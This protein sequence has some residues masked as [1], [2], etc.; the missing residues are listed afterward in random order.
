MF[1]EMREVVDDVSIRAPLTLFEGV[2][3][4]WIH[5]RVIF[6]IVVIIHDHR[7]RFYICSVAPDDRENLLYWHRSSSSCEHR[8]PTLVLVITFLTIISIWVCLRSRN[9]I[10]RIGRIRDGT[11][12]WNTSCSYLSKSPKWLV[13]SQCSTVSWMHS[14]ISN[15]S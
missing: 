2:K 6:R 4:W 9:H 14:G 3:G 13:R 12:K 1:L 10:C 7:L 5:V 11:G 15:Q 8:C